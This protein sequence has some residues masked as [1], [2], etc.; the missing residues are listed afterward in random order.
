LDD[1]WRWLNQQAENVSLSFGLLN[2]GLEPRRQRE[3]EDGATRLM[4][5]GP[6]S[7]VMGLDDKAANRKA[8]PHSGGLRGDK[9]LENP[10]VILLSYARPR[11]ATATSKPSAGLDSVL[12]TLRQPRLN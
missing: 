5:V 9:G 4:L 12:T 6:Q 1:R 3:P 2:I 8:N 10:L 7:P 11:V